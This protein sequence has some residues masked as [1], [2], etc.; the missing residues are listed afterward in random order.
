MHRR[1]NLE[2]TGMT[3]SYLCDSANMGLPD[4]RIVGARV[5]HGERVAG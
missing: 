4:R 5:A 3:V 1:F 2:N